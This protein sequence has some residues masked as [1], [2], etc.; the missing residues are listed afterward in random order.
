MFAARDSI[1]SCALDKS[2]EVMPS[3]LTVNEGVAPSLLTVSTDSFGELN[4]PSVFLLIRE[5]IVPPVPCKLAMLMCCSS[6]SSKLIT[7]SLRVRSLMPISATPLSSELLSF[8]SVGVHWAPS[9]SPNFKPVTSIVL[10]SACPVP[11]EVTAFPFQNEFSPERL[12]RTVE[13]VRFRLLNTPVISP[14]L[15]PKRA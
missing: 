9:E 13:K 7:P 5:L 3:Y 2:S 14:L 1:S 11:Y 15:L 6:P 4:V 12:T 8:T 10:G